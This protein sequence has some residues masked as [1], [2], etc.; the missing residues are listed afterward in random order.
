MYYLDASHILKKKKAYGIRRL[1][2][3]LR[4]DKNEHSQKITKLYCRCHWKAIIVGIK[5]ALEN[6]ALFNNKFV[7]TGLFTEA[8]LVQYE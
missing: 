5:Q 6:Y 2:F 8:I 3:L 1:E 4:R 7:N